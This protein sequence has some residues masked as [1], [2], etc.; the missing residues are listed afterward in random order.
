MRGIEAIN[1][2]KTNAYIDGFNLYYGAVKKNYGS[3]TNPTYYKWLNVERLLQNILNPKPT[4]SKIKYF[5]ARITSLPEDPQAPSRQALYLKALKTLKNLEI[6]Y[7]HF[8]KTPKFIP[9]F[10]LK[11]KNFIPSEESSSRELDKLIKKL[12]GLLS[13]IKDLDPKFKFK[14]QR[15][16]E[17]GSDVNLATHLLLD[18]FQEEYDRAIIVTND[19]DLFT[20]IKVIKT[21][22]NK[23]VAIISPHKKASGKLLNLFSKAKVESKELKGSREFIQVIKESHLKKS[24]F[25]NTL[26]DHRGAFSKPDSW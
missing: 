25:N 3:D 6:Y 26:S 17:K 14:F 11:D 7:G 16:E 1:A 19:S 9:L 24:Q 12:E 4:I 15:R 23:K 8:L 2:N 20:P 18:A 13:E 22:L 5:T 21:V 10:P